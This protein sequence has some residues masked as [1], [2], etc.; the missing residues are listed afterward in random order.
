MLYV[1]PRKTH[2][3]GFICSDNF[4]NCINF[5]THGC[6]VFQLSL[7]SIYAIFKGVI[8]LKKKS[9]LEELVAIP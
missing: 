5:S 7:L 4:G 2:T 3:C 8:D 1:R 6:D 9:L